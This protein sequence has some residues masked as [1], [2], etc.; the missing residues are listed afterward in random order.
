MY[1]VMVQQQ[2][3]ANRNANTCLL[4]HGTYRH[5]AHTVMLQQQRVWHMPKKQMQTPE[6]MHST[7]I[8]ILYG[9]LDDD[10][11]H[12]L[13]HRHDPPQDGLL[14]CLPEA[15]YVVAGK[16]VRMPS[17]SQLLHQGPVNTSKAEL[18][19]GQ[20]IIKTSHLLNNG[21]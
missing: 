1:T 15:V 9:M 16:C 5:M 7:V 17:E 8:F 19:Y 2:C 4:A 6:I 18:G 20:G 21:G 12:C 13:R 11:V 10:L 14:L 3:N